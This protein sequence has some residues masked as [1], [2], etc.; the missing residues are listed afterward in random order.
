MEMSEHKHIVDDVKKHAAGGH[1][2]HSEH[3]KKHAAGHVLE[4][5]K[6]K[7]LCGGG[8]AK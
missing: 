2:H 6:V 4:H 1:S 3:Y 7:K 8:K 5:E